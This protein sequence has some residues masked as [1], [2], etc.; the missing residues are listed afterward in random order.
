M[1][2]V[3]PSLRCGSS[4]HGSALLFT[5]VG[6]FGLPLG[7]CWA[8][9]GFNVSTMCLLLHLRCSSH[10]CSL[11]RSRK[12]SHDCSTGISSRYG[13]K[14]RFVFATRIVLRS[15]RCGGLFMAK[16]IPIGAVHRS[17]PT[18]GHT[19]RRP[20]TDGEFRNDLRIHE[21]TSEKHKRIISQRG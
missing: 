16:T 13:S 10:L 7:D 6:V 11:E 18:C 19:F 1:C 21:E 12:T 2:C 4:T 20:L 17:C 3:A 5:I 9:C 15:P 14:V 8:G